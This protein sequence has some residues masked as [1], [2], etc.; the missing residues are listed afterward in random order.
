MRVGRAS[1]CVSN[2]SP[3]PSELSLYSIADAVQ[4]RTS[5]RENSSLREST[6]TS[7]SDPDADVAS[8]ADGT[9]NPRRRQRHQVN[10]MCIPVHPAG[11]YGSLSQTVR[12]MLGST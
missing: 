9:R 4:L 1:R 8:C 7:G 3:L 2:L 6:S 11:R 5:Q 12:V 10:G